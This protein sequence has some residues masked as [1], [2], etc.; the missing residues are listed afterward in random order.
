MKHG[1]KFIAL[2]DDARTRISETNVQ[3]VKKL[4]D[5]NAAFYLVDVREESEWNNGHLPGAIHLSKG[6]IERDIEARIPDVEAK[7]VLYCGGGYRSA[8]AADNLQK[9]GYKNVI[10]MDGGFRGWKEAGLELEMD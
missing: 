7:I 2:A 10:S 1:I 4:L 6:I 9:M 8:L 3:E 5:E